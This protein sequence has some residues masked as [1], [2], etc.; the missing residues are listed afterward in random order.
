MLVKS[1]AI[2]IIVFFIG[3]GVHA[4][5]GITGEDNALISTINGNTLYVGGSGQ[6]NYTMIQDAINDS[7]DGD[8]VFVFDDSSP[9]FENVLVDKSINLI[10][11]DKDTT[12]IEADN[13]S[14]S[15]VFVSSNWV[16]I[17]GF[18]IRN[19]DTGISLGY[20]SGSNTI[21][22]NTIS[23]N[24]NN[25]IYLRSKHNTIKGNNISKNGDNGIKIF[26]DYNTITGNTIS[27]NKCGIRLCYQRG[28]VTFGSN[29][30][31]ILRNNFLDNERDA[32]FEGEIRGLNN[33]WRQNYWNTPRTFPKL[34]F[35][36][37]WI[38]IIMSIP[39]GIPWI[40]IDWFPAKEPYDIEN[41]NLLE[42][43]K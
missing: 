35:G 4:T 22:R 8:T 25:G 37:V 40:N 27:N 31:T 34:I 39:V 7:I 16:N 14:R 18:T 11:K 29:Y 28:F 33:R 20:Y 23:D 38:E 21:T 9:Y 26:S 41:I 19:G 30:N 36:L 12:F 43:L 1:L 10:G 24:K 3:A 6:G 13:N 42:E 17:S 2:V 5:C 15:V 32:F